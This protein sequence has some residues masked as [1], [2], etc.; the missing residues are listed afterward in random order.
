MFKALNIQNLKQAGEFPRFHADLTTQ[1]SG[2]SPYPASLESE[3]RLMV[4]ILEDAVQCY[5][6]Y[7]AAETDAGKR[8]FRDA[9]R[10]LFGQTEDWI[11]SFENICACVGIN[12]QYFR[13]GLSHWQ[14]STSS[15]PSAGSRPCRRDRTAAAGP[16]AL[17]D[18]R[19]A[20]F[21]R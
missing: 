16:G 10:W 5:Q 6:R 13:A 4:M 11:Y 1:Y 17:T 19:S 7:F 21:P 20:D 14:K 9:E 2:G 8:E 18:R 15:E 12:P 3:I